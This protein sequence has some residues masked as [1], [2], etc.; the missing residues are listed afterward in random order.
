MPKATTTRKK[1]KKQGK[2]KNKPSNQRYLA[3]RRWITNKAKRVSRMMK[4]FPKY[5]PGN[6]TVD[7]RVLV[8]QML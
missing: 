4:K 3:S 6:L 8:R 5:N 1:G 2:N 7:V